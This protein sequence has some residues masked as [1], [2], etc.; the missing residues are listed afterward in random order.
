[1]IGTDAHLHSKSELRPWLAQRR[2]RAT[3][4]LR[5]ACI[6][7]TGL[8]PY[9]TKFGGHDIKH[10]N[11]VGTRNE[12]VS[13][14]GLLSGDC[15]EVRQNRYWQSQRLRDL[16]QKDERVQ[17][18]QIKGDMTMLNTRRV[19]LSLICFALAGTFSANAA[20]YPSRPIR[21]IVPFGAGGSVDLVA[22]LMAQAMSERFG[23]Q[24]FVEDRPG[25]GT[26]IATQALAKATPDGY[27]IMMADTAL[28]SAPAVVKDLPYDTLRDIAPIVLVGS[29]PVVLAV[30]KSSPVHTLAD[31]IKLAKSKPGKL[32][33]GS[34]GVGSMLYLASE[35]FKVQAGVDIQQIPYKSTADV[36]LA[37]A[38]GDVNMVIAAAPA[39]IGQRDQLRFLAVSSRSRLESLPNVPTFAEAGMPDFDVQNWQGL[40]APAATKPEIIVR[41]NKMVNEI[42]ADHNVRSRLEKLAVIVSGGTPQQF[43][44][45][46]AADL[47][48]WPKVVHAAGYEAK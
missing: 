36:T 28:G 1:M 3:A 38:S 10:L 16:K 15:S 27:T 14:A 4:A 44:R 39:L 22:R 24:V 21:M 46:L 30:S 34:A 9:P 7:F 6:L 43:S 45:L 11:R 13:L 32:N 41:L 40:I 35:L 17:N 25:G 29:L 2:Q 18:Q 5:H 20:D 23:R 26:V 8:R 19:L 31:L 37:L 47:T 42:I 12:G 48:R 33:Y